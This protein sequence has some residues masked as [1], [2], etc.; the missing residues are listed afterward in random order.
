M[1]Q[2]RVEDETCLE[3]EGE[4]FFDLVVANPP[5][6]LRKDLTA[7]APEICLYEDLRA[8]DG[9]PQGLDV[10]LPIIKLADKVG[11]VVTEHGNSCVC[12]LEKN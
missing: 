8:L 6:V 9:G 2:L 3:D 10:I 11:A 12:C 4:A 7:L 5:Y 1:L